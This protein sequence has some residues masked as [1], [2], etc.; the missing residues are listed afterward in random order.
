M[1]C[2]SFTYYFRTEEQW[3]EFMSNIIDL[4]NI[5]KAKIDV[6]R[7]SSGDVKL[8]D[9]MA[10]LAKKYR[11]EIIKGKSHDELILAMKELTLSI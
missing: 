5:K 9:F 8:F 6:V 3:V 11:S 2:Y 10:C 1:V 7:M 4:Q